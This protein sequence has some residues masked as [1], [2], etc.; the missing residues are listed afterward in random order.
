MARRQP[1]R[2]L[3]L[4]AVA[5]AIL[6]SVAGLQIY[7]V[8]TIDQST[9][10]GFGFG[11]FATYDGESARWASAFVVDEF[12]EAEQV[13]FPSV[14]FDV[15]AAAIV[16]PSDSNVRHLAQ[17]AAREIREAG[18]GFEQ[19]RIVVG[20]PQ[21]VGRSGSELHV[22]QRVYNAIEVAG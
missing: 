14:D 22:R 8:H 7:R 21:I 10:S 1:K 9:W 12:G 18:L 15:Y 5:P 11:M 3:W 13:G 6:L 4:A 20:G 16:A 17:A 19:V 2:S